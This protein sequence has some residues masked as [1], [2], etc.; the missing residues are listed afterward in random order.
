MA[1]TVYDVVIINTDD[2]QCTDQHQ[3]RP[4]YTKW[5]FKSTNRRDDMVHLRAM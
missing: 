4:L 2:H 5:I 3:N 1:S